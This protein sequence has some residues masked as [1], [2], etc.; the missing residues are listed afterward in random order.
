MKRVLLAFVL[1]AVGLVLLLSYDVPTPPSIAL[2][3]PAGAGSGSDGGAGPSS[4]TPAGSTAPPS[5]GAPPADGQPTD[6]QPRTLVGS[7]IDTE[8]GPVQVQVTMRGPSISDVSVLQYPNG[9]G[10][11][12]EINSVA[13]PQLV[14]QALAAQSADIQMVSGATYTSQGF[15]ASLQSALDQA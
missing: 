3:V 7:V 14:D 10:R 9:G 12:T 13:L 2:P 5:S 4:S 11:D 8:Q 6:S 1:T 15:I